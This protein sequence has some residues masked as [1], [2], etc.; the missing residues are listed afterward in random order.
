[1]MTEIPLP[2]HQPDPVTEGWHEVAAVMHEWHPALQD[3]ARGHL[4]KRGIEL[5]PEHHQ[6]HVDIARPIVPDID[7]APPEEQDLV[8]E[9]IEIGQEALSVT[10]VRAS[11]IITP[12]QYETADTIPNNESSEDDHAFQSAFIKTKTKLEC[13]KQLK[14]ERLTRRREDV[15]PR[16]VRAYEDRYGEPP[17]AEWIAA[18]TAAPERSLRMN[19]QKLALLRP[20]SEADV[21]YRKK[22]LNELPRSIREKIP[23]N[24]PLKFHGTSI[25]TAQE[26]IASGEI[27]S[28]VDRLGIATSYDTSD[29]VSVTAPESI[30]VTLES[31]SGL[32]E[33]NCAMPAGCVFVLLP[34]TKEDAHTG[35]S[36]LM[37]NVI[38]K[39]HPD[40]LFAIMTSSENVDRVKQWAEEAGVDPSKVAE[41]FGFAD[42][43]DILKKSIEQGTAHVQDYLQY[44][45]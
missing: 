26:I 20:S 43:L 39:E 28:S 17:S 25:Y 31:Y 12:E 29:Q 33:E 27:S 15:L 10:D 6:Q 4:E 5:T 38:F 9:V 45:L 7:T 3:I 44:P 40:Q 18:F 34:A 30:E 41:F 8:G 19:E 24:L 23:P 13:T 36:L 11:D 2:A 42:S 16:R 14:E 22:V 35:S 21:A 1:M 32:M 37:S